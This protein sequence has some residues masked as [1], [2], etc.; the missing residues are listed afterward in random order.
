MI[1]SSGTIAR[2]EHPRAGARHKNNRARKG[3]TR[4]PRAGGE[5]LLLQAPDAEAE[6][7]VADR[8][9]DIIAR[10]RGTRR[11]LYRNNAQSRA[12]GSCR[13]SLLS[14]NSAGASYEAPRSRI[15]WLSSSRS[16]AENIALGRIVIP[17]PGLAR[18]H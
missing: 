18:R 10:E 2:D 8:S 17:P 15:R 6:P 14:Y 4:G 12:S 7:W 11:R 3:K 1:G 13:R 16:T 9:T 5:K